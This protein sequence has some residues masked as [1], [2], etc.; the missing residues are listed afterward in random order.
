MTP[1]AAPVGVRFEHRTDEGPVLGIGTSTPRLSWV[2][3][4]ADPSFAQ[5][6]Y[7]VEVDRGAGEAEVFR[8][9]GAEQVLVP[10]P[11]EP[12]ASREVARLRVR[13][14]GAGALSE[15]SEP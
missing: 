4:A 10:W 11:A 12:L 1:I 14:A 2:V 7:E 8:V 6:A 5:E 9:A 15:W 13:V 3:P